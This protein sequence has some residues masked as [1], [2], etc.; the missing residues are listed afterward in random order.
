MVAFLR[1]LLVSLAVIFWGLAFPQYASLAQDGTNE[2]ANKATKVLDFELR[3]IALVGL[4][5]VLRQANANAK[6]RE[7]L[8]VQRKK[9]QEEFRQI[10]LELQETERD[11]LVK[12][13]QIAKDE[14][15]KMVNAFQRRVASVQKDIQYKRQSIDSAYQKA[16]NEIRQLAI[17]EIKKIATE[18]K[19]DLILN[20]EA[21]IM[22][23]PHLNISD[24][25]LNRL[26][27]RTKN[28]RIEVE[29]KK[30]AA[31]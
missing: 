30:P 14:Y 1:H 20:R 6:I 26:N 5:G 18:R 9:F 4:D 8:D 21:G 24:E 12:R 13:E 16:L 3:R 10:E 31:Q 15:D 25:V 2:L 7:L 29:M 27:E 17:D 23:L 11:L 19:I 22:F 28:A